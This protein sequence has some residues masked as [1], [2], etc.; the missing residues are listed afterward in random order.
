MISEQ[1]AVDSQQSAV[2]S[3]VMTEDMEGGSGGT[4]FLDFESYRV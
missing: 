2:I 4:S 3:E 1:S